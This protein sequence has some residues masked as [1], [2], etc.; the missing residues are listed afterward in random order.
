[1]E[2]I[3]LKKINIQTKNTG[4]KVRTL[5]DLIKFLKAVKKGT[6]GAGD[7]EVTFYNQMWGDSDILTRINYIEGYY[8]HKEHLVLI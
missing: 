4:G 8:K 1:M 6:P 3:N 7:M 5:N 2:P